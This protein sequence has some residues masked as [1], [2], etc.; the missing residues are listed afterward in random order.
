MS[1]ETAKGIRQA[2]EKVENSIPSYI[3]RNGFEKARVLR[4]FTEIEPI[5]DTVDHL[6]G[7]VCGG[8]V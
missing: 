2:E 1:S 6:G 5:F 7:V 3:S 4:G 8:Y